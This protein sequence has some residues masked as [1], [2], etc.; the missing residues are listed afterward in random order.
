M[1]ASKFALLGLLA[2]GAAGCTAYVEA[3]PPPPPAVAAEVEVGGG[4]EVDLGVFYS[5]LGGYGEWIERPGYGRVWY[6]TAVQVGW[7][8]YLHGRWVVTDYGWTWVS[9]EDF[10]WA[11]YH[12]GR[13]YQDAE[14]G[15][16][17][18]P[19][20]VWGPA[21][22]SFQRGGGYIGWAPLPPAVGFHAGI[23]IQLGGVAIAAGAYS[24]CEERAFLHPQIATVIV[25]P[26]RNV[27]I[28][29]NTTNITNYTVVN[30]KVVNQSVS[31]QHIEQA[32]GQK[33]QR[34]QLAS[35]ATK[36]ASTIQGNQIAIYKPSL[37]AKAQANGAAQG[38]QRTA[39]AGGNAAAGGNA[40]SAGKAG[41]PGAAG[42]GGTASA[43]G[44]RGGQASQGGQAAQGGQASQGSQGVQGGQMPGA[45]DRQQRLPAQGGAAQTGGG[46]DHSTQ[47]RDAHPAG[48]PGSAGASTAGGGYGAEDLKHR[49]QAEK[50]QLAAKHAA[51]RSQLRSAHQQ[52]L[53]G[54]KGG[55][56]ANGANAGSG[57]NAADLKRKHDAEMRALQQ[58]HQKEQAALDARHKQEKAQA[59]AAKSAARKGQKQNKR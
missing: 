40:G 42:S 35:A 22:V 52:E 2:G 57:A 43:Q 32:T 47:A 56:G 30:N 45:S 29:N 36:G 21:W 1:N 49:H 23:G 14:V 15:W 33:V 17:W 41:A 28:I 26:A 20:T 58:Q 25:P 55:P 24:F 39:G 44:A 38:S 48:G 13:W 3:P 34:Y 31:V 19:G 18:V 4:G 16:V 12:Y 54:A 37:Q 50:A 11:T 46:Q 51:E 6:P 59:A 27:T 53:A 7:R 8:P 9:S 10:G 5:G